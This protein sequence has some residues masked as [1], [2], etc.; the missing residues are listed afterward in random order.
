MDL[1]AR[2]WFNKLQLSYAFTYHAWSTHCANCLLPEILFLALTKLSCNKCQVVHYHS[3]RLLSYAA[4][5]LP[6]FPDYSKI[7][8]VQEHY[9]LNASYLTPLLGVHSSVQ[10]RYSCILRLESQLC[11]NSVS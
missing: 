9:I 11:D 5:Y 3:N 2:L 6:T 7:T 8:G 10:P 1:G 4:Q